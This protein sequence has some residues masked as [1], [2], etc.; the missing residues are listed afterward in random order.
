[1][2]A[3]VGVFR[4]WAEQRAAGMSFLLSLAC[5]EQ[6]TF[7]PLARRT[8]PQRLKRRACVAQRD[9]WR[10]AKQ[11]CAIACDGTDVKKKHTAQSS[12]QQ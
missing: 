11:K 1:M 3:L 6:H 4:P 5:G 9:P 7:W 12:D 8:R 10:P 2:R